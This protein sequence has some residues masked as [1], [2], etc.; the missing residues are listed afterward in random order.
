MWQKTFVFGCPECEMGF[1][2]ECANYSFIHLCCGRFVQWLTFGYI[3][4]STND[5]RKITI[6]RKFRLSINTSTGISFCMFNWKSSFAFSL[7]LSILLNHKIKNKI[8]N[9]IQVNKHRISN[10]INLQFS[11]YSF[12]NISLVTYKVIYLIFLKESLKYII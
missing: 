4:T 8:H 1:M 12:F 11:V 5:P 2:G 10:V 7:K 9:S 6:G 3:T